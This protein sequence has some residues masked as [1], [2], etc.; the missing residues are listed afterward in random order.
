M[1]LQL[2][3][4]LLT[5]EIIYIE[6]IARDSKDTRL[7]ALDRETRI[8][9]EDCVLSLLEMRA[10]E[11][12][13][14]AALHRADCRHAAKRIHIDVKI[15]LQKA[16]GLLFQLRN[17]V[18]VWILGSHARVERLLFRFDANTHRRKARNTHF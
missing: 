5:T 15:G 16:R 13:G 10:E 2:R 17:A 4:Q 6:G 3:A 8:N 9:E 7:S 12:C 11:E 1:S 18:D 14:E